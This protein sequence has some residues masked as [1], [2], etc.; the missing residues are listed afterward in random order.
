MERPP[1]NLIKRYLASENSNRCPLRE[2]SGQHNPP[3]ET[4]IVF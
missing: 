1:I 3:G 4:L 2:L